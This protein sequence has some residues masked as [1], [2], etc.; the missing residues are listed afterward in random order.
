MSDLTHIHSL[1]HDGHKDPPHRLCRIV[2]GVEGMN[3]FYIIEF[4]DGTRIMSHD[5]C[6]TEIRNDS[7]E[8][9]VIEAAEKPI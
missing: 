3:R 5:S 8:K 1:L 9:I 2:G 6:L 4:K 7:K